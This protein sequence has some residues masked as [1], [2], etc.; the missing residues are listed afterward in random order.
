MSEFK[1]VVL[2]NIYCEINITES[3]DLLKN[4]EIKIHLLQNDDLNWFKQLYEI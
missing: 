1:N 3:K 4:V 2:T